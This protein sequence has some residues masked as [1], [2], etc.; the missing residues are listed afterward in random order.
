MTNLEANLGYKYPYDHN[1]IFKKNP[2]VLFKT[3]LRER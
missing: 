2:G 1:I 3:F